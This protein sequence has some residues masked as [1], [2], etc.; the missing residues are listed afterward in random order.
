MNGD[1]FPASCVFNIDKAGQNQY[2]E[3]HSMKVIVSA[4][5]T[6]STI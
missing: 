3:A 1:K 2:V 6:N 5:Y 4:F